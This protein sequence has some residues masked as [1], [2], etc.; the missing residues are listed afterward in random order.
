M[1]YICLAVIAVFSAVSLQAQVDRSKMPEPGPAPEL[2]LKEPQ[3]F[4]LNNG[5]KVMVV[6]NHKLPRVS[7][8]LTID[9]PPI[10]EG[11]KAGVS[12][13]TGSLIGKG[14]KNIPKD[15]FN[16]EIDFLG[17]Q[18]SFGSSG[19]YASSLSKY[20]PRMMELMADAA[21]N[22]NFTQEEFDKERDKIITG[23]KTQEKDVP[24]IASRVQRVL[25]YGKN[26]PY[27]EFTT[28]A[29]IN[30]VNLADV[31]GFY[32]D[33]FVPANAYLII[34]GDVDFN[35]AKQLA[36]DYFTPWTKA[37]PPSFSFSK[38][39]DVQ[40]T[41]I[42]FVDMP[43]AVQSEIAVQNLVPLKMS[44]AD[45]LPALVANQILGGGGEG[46]LFLNLREDKGYTYGSYSS[47]G[48][49][50]YEVSRFRATASVR[51]MVTDSSIVELLKEIDRMATTPVSE[52]ELANTK[53]KYAG[54]FIMA[55]EKPQTIAGYALNI[56]TENLPKDFY[57]TYLE[58]LEKITV[59]DVQ[60]AA[61]KYFSSKNARVVVVGKGREILENLEKVTVKGSNIPVLYFDKTGEKTVKP[62][63]DSA[64]PKGITAN[65]IIE[66]YIAAIGGKD[67]LRQLESVYMAATTEMQGMQLDLEMKK[68]SK[69][70][71]MQDI[72]MGGNSMSKTV[73]NGNKG[74]ATGQGQRKEFTDEEIS[75]V[76]EEAAPFPE[77]NYLT[78]SNIS[79]EGAETV[80]DKKVYVV[81]VTDNKTVYYD[82]ETG[83]K[84]QENTNMEMQGQQVSQ[85]ILYN[86]YKAV[87]GIL[88]PF[89]FIQ[90]VGP[91]KMEFTVNEIK[92]NEGVLPTDFE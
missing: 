43:N 79:F 22:P 20:F 35:T 61:K 86:D 90:S 65:S 71:F 29:S 11:K 30:N 15:E 41:Q 7:I 16:E 28:E 56:E 34:I 8:Q 33:Y 88:F 68:T 25:A 58:R 87:S 74:Y 27:G 92:V 3:S 51:N 17:A 73:L 14:S 82:S 67:A 45:Y 48:N 66:K 6:E 24:A 42:N 21:I 59:A 40:Y 12:G 75:K 70:Q 46:R 50:K 5:L 31:E 44:D 39:R 91:Q 32:R 76:K 4:Q 49:D 84:L 69:N 63:Y 81:K 89:S 64:L 78:N 1:K 52:K 77:L 47:V 9:N 10:L 53:A 54:R 2:N 18:M 85:T 23:L 36:E 37:V 57:K 62:D 83:L 60:N 55:L 13:L 80:G 19:A 72:K 38:P 26:H